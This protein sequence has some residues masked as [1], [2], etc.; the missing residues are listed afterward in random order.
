MKINILINYYFKPLAEEDFQLLFEWQ[1]QPH[2]LW[3]WQTV[4]EWP[5]F[6]K[7]YRDHIACDH[8][9]PFIVYFNDIPIGYVQY[10]L[11]EKL[12]D[13]V[14]RNIFKQPENVVG[15]DIF[16]GNPDFVAR[17]HG[18]NCMK[19]FIKMLFQKPK[20]EMVIVDPR[21]ENTLAINCFTKV[22]FQP[23]NCKEEAPTNIILMGLGKKDFNF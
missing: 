14:I 4:N 9:F 12:D 16:I 11:V 5:E 1:N 23:I 15:L 13:E 6:V 19:A 22:G 20:I 18:K 3:W 2:V 10:Y 7:K 8:I 21:P 17:G